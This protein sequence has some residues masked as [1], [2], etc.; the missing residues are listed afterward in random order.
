[1]KIIPEE[2]EVAIDAIPLA[3][4]SPS[5][6]GWKVHKEGRKCYYQIMR[7]DGKSQMYMIFS[8]L[9]K[10]FDKED[11]EDLYKF[12]KA[13]YES[14]RSVEDLDLILWGDLKIMFEPHIEDKVWRNQQEYKSVDLEAYEALNYYSEDQYI[15]SI[16]EDTAYLY[17][18]SPKTTEEQSSI[19]RIQRTQYAIFKIWNQYNIL[20]DIK[21]GPYSKKSP[22][23]RI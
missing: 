8:Q 3:V 22:I 18:H 9:F 14:T 21:G 7:A 13:K 16:K 12:V 4:K 23:R 10:S 5:I 19:R 2:E 11:L 17:L 1:M 6:V 15:V 20:E